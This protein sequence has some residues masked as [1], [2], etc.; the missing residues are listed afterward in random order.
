M[1]KFAWILAAGLGTRMKSDKAKVLHAVLD[2]PMILY[3]V[4]VAQQITNNNVIV[5]VGHQADK[6]R[7]VV[8]K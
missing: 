7:A 3:V 6:V 1:S 5:V 8:S 2:R 4:E